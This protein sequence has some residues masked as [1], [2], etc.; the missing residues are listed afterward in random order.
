M[1][2]VVDFAAIKGLTDVLLEK[3]E[4]RFVAEM[5]N[6]LRSSRQQVVDAHY[7]MTFAQQ[8]IAQMRSDKTRSACYEY[9]HNAA[10][11]MKS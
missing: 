8:R 11:S 3:F 6:V 5:S 10:S 9:T 4:A 7:R 1:E 2:N